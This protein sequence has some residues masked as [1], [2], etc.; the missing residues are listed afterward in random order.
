MNIKR[1]I[2]LINGG[3][4]YLYDRKNEKIY[5]INDEYIEELESPIEQLAKFCPYIEEGEE[6]EDD[7]YNIDLRRH[8]L[9]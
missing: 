1:F 3:T 4:I 6:F 2:K 9:N 7:R 5:L 8:T